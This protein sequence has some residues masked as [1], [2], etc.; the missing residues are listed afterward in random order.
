MTKTSIERREVWSGLLRLS[1]WGL[2]LTTLLLIGTGWLLNHA[3][4][5]ANAAS[6]YHYIAGALF[7]ISLILRLYLLFYDRLTGKWQFLS[8]EQISRENLSAMLK[9][10][11]TFGKSPLPHWYAHNPAWIVVYVFTFILMGLASLSGHFM[12]DHPVMLGMYLPHL[13]SIVTLLITWFAA[14]H[15]VAVVMHD[16][17]GD[18]AD[19]SAMI[20]GHRIF[21]LKPIQTENQPGVHTFSIKDLHIKPKNPDKT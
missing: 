3:P 9:F 10:Y 8:P 16:L 14:L 5:V 18:A 4:S 20:N 2:A 11:L 13:H 15:T 1:H 21:V 19:T 17:K 6:D 12:S 7:S